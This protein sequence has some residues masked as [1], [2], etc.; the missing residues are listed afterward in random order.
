MYLPLQGASMRSRAL[1][2]CG[3]RRI[4]VPFVNLA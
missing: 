2:H 4:V 1:H 3:N